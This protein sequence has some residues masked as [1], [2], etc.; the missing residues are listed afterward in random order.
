[1]RSAIL[2]AGMNDEVVIADA[3]REYR[4]RL[5]GQSAIAFCVTIEHSQAVA[6]AF[7]AAGIKAAHVDG[8]TPAAERRQLIERLAAG[9]IR[10]SLQLRSDQ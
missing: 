5:A 2:R 4:E 7:R 8:D 1:M 9:E 3:V 10:T 6:R